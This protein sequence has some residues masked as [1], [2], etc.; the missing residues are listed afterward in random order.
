MYSI[1][2][3]AGGWVADINILYFNSERKL[4]MES[5]EKDEKYFEIFQRNIRIYTIEKMTI[6]TKTK[7]LII[8]F[9]ILE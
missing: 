7:Y 8:V 1:H 3:Q 5:R 2:I 9:K 4:L 6:K